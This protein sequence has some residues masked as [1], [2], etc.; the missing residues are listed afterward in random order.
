MAYARH[1]VTSVSTSAV[2]I[3]GTQFPGWLLKNTHASEILYIGGTGVTVAA[4]FPIDPGAVFSPDAP[5]HASLLGRPE[6]R[7]FGISPSAT[8]SVR[9]LIPARLDR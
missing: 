7:L 6:D 1:A 8:I 5:S 2:A 3:E 4:G 9:V